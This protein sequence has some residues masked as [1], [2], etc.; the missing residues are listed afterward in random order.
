MPGSLSAVIADDLGDLIDDYGPEMVI[1]AIGESARANVRNM[2]YITGILKNWAAG[3]DKPQP[4]IV[5]APNGKPRAS[6]SPNGRGMS[7]VER[8]LAAVEAVRQM[9]QQQEAH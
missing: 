9:L 2:R 6:P 4:A 8:S 5:S 3:S 1:R 7:K